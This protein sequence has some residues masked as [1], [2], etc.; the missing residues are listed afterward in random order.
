MNNYN[1]EKINL[2]HC[3]LPPRYFDKMHYRNI[4]ILKKWK[5]IN[6]KFDINQ[7]IYT[8]NDCINFLQSFEKKYNF[9]VLNFFE[10][11]KDGR[12]KADLWRMCLLYEY[13]GIYSDIDQEPL[14]SLDLFLD[15]NKIDF[16]SASNM[17]RDS[18]SIGFIY[19]KPNSKIIYDT[20]NIMI[21]KYLTNH[22]NMSGTWSMAESILKSCNL[23]ECPIG[24]INIKEER[25][26]FL[27]E[28]GDFSLQGQSHLN[29]FYF[30]DII[31]NTNV[32]KT[33]Y[34]TY[35][36][37]QFDQNG[38]IEIPEYMKVI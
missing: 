37:D 28:V 13:G 10:K 9:K 18:I 33:R 23:K 35:Y 6:N 21:N 24:Q 31:N 36:Y 16:L 2:F 19:S 22:E 29:S 25:C 3:I 34:E 12:F 1:K 27:H 38:F 26:F 7:K 8:Y 4:E 5:Q 11:E 30:K 32:I 17:H 15:T 20:I 14:C